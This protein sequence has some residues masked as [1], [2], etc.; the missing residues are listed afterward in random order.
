MSNIC[1]PILSLFGGFLIGCSFTIMLCDSLVDEG[2]YVTKEK[3]YICAEIV[4]E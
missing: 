1:L 4:D 2:T 3:T